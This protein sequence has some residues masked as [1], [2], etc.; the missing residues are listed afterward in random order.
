MCFQGQVDIGPEV[1]S[2]RVS[3]SELIT[4]SVYKRRGEEGEGGE[5]GDAPGS[6][7]HSAS[8]GLPAGGNIS[9]QAAAVASTR[10]SVG[11]D[12]EGGGGLGANRDQARGEQE[13]HGSSGLEHTTAALVAAGPPSDAPPEVKRHHPAYR[14]GK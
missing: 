6:S 4:S 3:S 8:P 12:V 10:A 14:T 7:S 2:C 1:R 9:T 13:E 5:G 11:G